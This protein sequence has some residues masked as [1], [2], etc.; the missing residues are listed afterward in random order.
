[1]TGGDS[2]R[3]EV[4][5]STA[6]LAPWVASPSPPPCTRRLG[7]L[8]TAMTDEQVVV[9]AGRQFWLG[10]L[11]GHDVVAVLSRIGKVA[12]AMTATLLVHEFGAERAIFTGTAGGL[13]P[14][15]G[16]RCRRRQ[17]VAAARHGRVAILSA[18]RSAA[19]RHRPLPRGEGLSA[20]LAEAAGN[21]LAE[22]SRAGRTTRSSPSNPPSW[23]VRH[24]HATG[25]RWPGCQRR[26]FRRQRGE[27]RRF[28][29]GCP[30]RSR[31][32]WK[33]RR[34]R[35][36]ATILAFPLPWCARLRPCR[37]LG[38]CRLQPL[39]LVDRE[40][41]QRR[42]CASLSARRRGERAIMIGRC[43]SRWTPSSGKTASYGR[44]RRAETWGS[45]HARIY[46][47]PMQHVARPLEGFGKGALEKRDA[48]PDASRRLRTRRHSASVAVQSIKVKPQ[49]EAASML[50]PTQAEFIADELVQAKRRERAKSQW[51]RARAV[52]LVYRSSSLQ[53]ISPSQ[54]AERLEQA[55]TSVSSKWSHLLACCALSALS[56]AALW[57]LSSSRLDSWL[58]ILIPLGFLP[59][60]GWH[61]YVVRRELGA[62]LAADF[63][64]ESISGPEV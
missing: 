17:R 44:R 31:S 42:H 16:R 35:R 11:D 58:G 7:A 15:A 34:W 49:N 27:A 2:L 47:L 1:M 36:S 6:I 8:L 41:L 46:S 22:R 33:G 9:L 18:S 14:R 45:L 63:T 55:S 40:P 21:V 23:H 53:K 51:A 32:R 60:L 4:F 12:A 13:R 3:R 52:P 61:A 5:T 54:Q 59:A 26:P 56:S 20:A 48:A 30:M 25:P 57:W 39:R 64:S 28:A 24:H 43:W 50:T 37:R 38:A 19:V 62:L 29:S 10:H